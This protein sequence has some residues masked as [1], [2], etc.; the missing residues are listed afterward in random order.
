DDAQN[1]IAEKFQ[2]LV[3]GNAPG[4]VRE[5]A[6]CEGKDE[7]FCIQIHSELGKERRCS[8]TRH[9]R[10]ERVCSA[11]PTAG[12]WVPRARAR[13]FPRGRSRTAGTALRSLLGTAG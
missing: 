3:G 8:L 5:A 4:F 7:E 10:H 13:G 2:P 11:P 12:Q 1:R 9:C 6:V